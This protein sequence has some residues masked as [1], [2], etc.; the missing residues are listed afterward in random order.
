MVAKMFGADN[1]IIKDTFLSDAETYFHS[2]IDSVNFRTRSAEAVR[3]INSFVAEKTHNKITNL[4]NKC[5]S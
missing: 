1:F 3:A 2:G 5:K 4:F